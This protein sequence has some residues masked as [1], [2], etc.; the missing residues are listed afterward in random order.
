MAVGS[1][2]QPPWGFQNGSQIPTPLS[3]PTVGARMS[4]QFLGQFLEPKPASGFGV[5]LDV[6]CNISKTMKSTTIR[7]TSEVHDMQEATEGCLFSS[8]EPQPLSWGRVAFD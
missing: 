6:E 8:V 4:L 1:T 7:R 3:A 2:F 5:G